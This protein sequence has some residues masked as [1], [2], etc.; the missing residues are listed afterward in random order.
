MEVEAVIWCPKC[1][2]PKYEIRRVPTGREGVHQHKSYPEG[3][4]EKLCEC[5]TRLERKP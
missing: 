2:K 3:R 1:E 4:D 5:G